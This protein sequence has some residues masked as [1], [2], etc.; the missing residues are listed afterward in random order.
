MALISGRTSDVDEH[1]CRAIF[2]GAEHSLVILVGYRRN[3]LHDTHVL[4]DG[5]SL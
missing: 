1:I 3:T 5:E 4:H 2:S